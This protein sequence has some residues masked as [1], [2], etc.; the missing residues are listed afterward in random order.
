MKIDK[1]SSM[2]FLLLLLFI[3]LKIPVIGLP[4][5]WDEITY[6]GIPF[7]LSREPVYPTKYFDNTYVRFTGMPPFHPHALALVYILFGYS[8][9]ITH[10]YAITWALIALLFTFKIGH[11]LGGFKTGIISTVF[12]AFSPVFF[13][14][15]GLVSRDIPLV[16]LVV[17]T[18]YFYLV[19]NQVLLLISSCFLV[20]TK[21]L[22]IFIVSALIFY[23]LF[24]KDRPRDLRN[25]KICL[26]IPIFVY[27]GWLGL[28]RI[29]SGE[30]FEY[31]ITLR[32]RDSSLLDP[33]LLKMTFNVFFIK[34]KEVI[35]TV[36]IAL[37]FIKTILLKKMFSSNEMVLISTILF[38]VIGVSIIVPWLLPR[39]LIFIK[40][41]FYVLGA[42][43]LTKL[44]KSE[45][46]QLVLSFVIILLFVSSWYARDDSAAGYLFGKNDRYFDAMINAF[47]KSI[48]E[49]NMEY[50][51]L[52]KAYKGSF[53]YISQNY[54]DAVI[55]RVHN[56][57]LEHY[58]VY[59]ELGYVNKPH[60]TIRLNE[61]LEILDRGCTNDLAN[62]VDAYSK[63]AYSNGIWTDLSDTRL[64]SIA[65]GD[66]DIL[67]VNEE[68]EGNY[69]F[70]EP[71]SESIGRD[72]PYGEIIFL[73]RIE[74]NRIGISI[75]KVQEKQIELP[76]ECRSR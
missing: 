71:F 74:V 51:D 46:M 73:K 35:I 19:D 29:I 53:E 21:E 44:F 12:L 40:P 54:P 24:I 38:G 45:S 17:L 64:D 11:L 68:F 16:A 9:E 49:K 75:Y 59:P 41:M 67:F 6:A 3:V 69:W 55:V 36:L 33:R 23:E 60:I 62:K 56:F 13:A 57:P 48:T 52:I 27:L 47:G 28:H 20:L 18:V 4:L 31:V 66:R 39:H 70:R 58:T 26:F 10:I 8:I 76:T 22:G 7:Q 2:I 65:I 37:Y 42:V 25:I 63:G 30:F 50:L 5:H 34:Q 1:H 14:Q 72:H 61:G 32:F 15:S 43:S